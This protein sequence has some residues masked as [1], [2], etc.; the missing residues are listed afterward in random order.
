M[1][2]LIKGIKHENKALFVFDVRHLPIFG[3]SEPLF[4]SM[5]D[6]RKQFRMFAMEKL[7][8]GEGED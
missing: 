8:N 4:V 2:I 6:H 7:G 1:K 3:D 5:S